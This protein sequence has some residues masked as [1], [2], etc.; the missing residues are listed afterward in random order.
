M[1]VL[2]TEVDGAA[3]WRVLEDMPNRFEFHEFKFC[4]QRELCYLPHVCDRSADRVLQSAKKKGAVLY[5]AGLWRKQGMWTKS[6]G[7]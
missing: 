5:A 4:I 7:N 2:G 3:V 6:E 1:K